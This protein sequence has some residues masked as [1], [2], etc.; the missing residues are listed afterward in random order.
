MQRSRGA[1][2][3]K[4]SDVEVQSCGVWSAEE[5]RSSGADRCGGAEGHRCTGP[6]DL[7]G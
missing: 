4:S 1:A 2:E 3:Q 7:A 6:K 5:Q